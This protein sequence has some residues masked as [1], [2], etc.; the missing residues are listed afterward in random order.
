VVVFVAF[1]GFGVAANAQE[2]HADRVRAA[3]RYLKVANMA[4][5]LENTFLETAKRLPHGK[6]KEF[7]EFMRSAVRIDVLENAV[8]LSMIK[9]FTAEELNALADFYGSSVGQSALAK[10]GIYMAEVNPVIQQE[11]QRAIQEWKRKNQ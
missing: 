11:T 3:E 8:L 5:M 7:I 6:R 9:V 1:L 2:S 4:Q 10:F